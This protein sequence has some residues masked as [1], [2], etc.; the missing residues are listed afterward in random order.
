[1]LGRT[2]SRTGENFSIGKESF[3][4]KRHRHITT[5]NELTYPLPTILSSP[6]SSIL[7]NILLK[8][9]EISTGMQIAQLWTIFYCCK[10]L[11]R[12]PL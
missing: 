9:P 1:M 5:L 3:I 6:F 10:N 2:D 4:M 11:C 7:F 12:F 8:I